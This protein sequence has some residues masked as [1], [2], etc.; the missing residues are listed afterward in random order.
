MTRSVLM[1]SLM[2]SLFLPAAALAQVAKPAADE[3]SARPFIDVRAVFGSKGLSEKTFGPVSQHAQLGLEVSWGSD[4][5]PVTIATDL[6]YSRGV[7]E[8]DGVH[9]RASTT[10]LAL[11]LRVY[12]RPG[13]WRFFAGAG[14][15][16]T[17]VQIVK[18]PDR[19]PFVGEYEH[20]SSGTTT[21]W[22]QAGVLVRMTERTHGGASV[23]GSYGRAKVF[24]DDRAEA[25]GLA[26]TLTVGMVFGNPRD[27]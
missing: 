5:Q 4:H 27:R 18:D 21:L 14:F 15:A 16:P 9:W 19:T 11:G 1:L 2:S 10:E 6:L 8:R 22:G 24:D 26:A 3:P 12:S 23:R 7:A 13:K 17:N 20:D 25:G